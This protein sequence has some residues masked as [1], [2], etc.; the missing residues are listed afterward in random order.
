M[1]FWQRF[2]YLLLGVAIA[3][4]GVWVVFFLKIQV[5]ESLYREVQG[6]FCKEEMPMNP[7]ECHIVLFPADTIFK[8]IVPECPDFV[9]FSREW[10]SYTV[11]PTYF[12][13]EGTCSFKKYLPYK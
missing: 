7:E 5:P 9:V 1:K 12:L 4:I 10:K 13:K 3:Y 8:H 6:T 11:F 2:V